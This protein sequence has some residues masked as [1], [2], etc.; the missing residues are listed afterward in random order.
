MPGL[1]RDV[2]WNEPANL[3]HVIGET[4]DGN[5]TIYVVEPHANAVYADAQ[6]PFTPQVTLVDAQR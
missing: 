2:V 3:V 4:A 6:L 5:P 1:V